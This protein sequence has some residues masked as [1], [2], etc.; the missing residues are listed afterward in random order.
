MNKSYLKIKKL[1]S[2]KQLAEQILYSI[3]IKNNN[4]HTDMNKYLRVYLLF[5]NIKKFYYNQAQINT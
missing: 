1:Y 2:N 5:I 4:I 3:R